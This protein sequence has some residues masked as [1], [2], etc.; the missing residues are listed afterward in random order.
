MLVLNIL[1]KVNKNDKKLNYNLYYKRFELHDYLY[2]FQG[3]SRIVMK[4]L[5]L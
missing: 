1:N 4:R 2:K 3:F 5:I